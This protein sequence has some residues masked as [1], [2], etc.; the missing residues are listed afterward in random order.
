MEGTY[1][2]FADMLKNL[3]QIDQDHR[4]V[5]DQFLRELKQ[6]NE[7]IHD[8]DKGVKFYA[9]TLD[10]EAIRTFVIDSKYSTSID[11]EAIAKAAT[12]QMK[13]E[14]RATMIVFVENK[15][16]VIF[17]VPCPDTVLPQYIHAEEM[18]DSINGGTGVVLFGF[19]SW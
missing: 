17:T 2:E 19:K 10:K 12:E 14:Q 13:E 11:N 3:F 5:L 15:K 18:I 9:F 7:D 16:G 6:G 4:V 1:Q 8:Y